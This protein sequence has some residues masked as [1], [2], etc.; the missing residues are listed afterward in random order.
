MF[1]R[2][3]VLLNG[4]RETKIIKR[5]SIFQIANPKIEELIFQSIDDLFQQ[6]GGDILQMVVRSCVQI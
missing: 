5:D 4:N 6:C 2:V 3:T 1:I